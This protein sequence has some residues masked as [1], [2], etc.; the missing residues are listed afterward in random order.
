MECFKSGVIFGEQDILHDCL[1]HEMRSW[2]VASS[3]G[4]GGAEKLKL[5]LGLGVKCKLT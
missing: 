5:E 2:A 1:K 4:G 3:F